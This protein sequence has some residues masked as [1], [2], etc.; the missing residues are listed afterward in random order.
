[1]ASL[2]DGMGRAECGMCLPPACAVISGRDP[3]NDNCP[4][5]NEIFLHGLTGGAAKPHADGWLL[6]VHVGQAGMGLMDS[7][8]LDEI[9]FPIRVLEERLLVDTEGAGR[10]CG[11][12]A[13]VTVM[14]ALGTD[15]DVM[16]GIDGHVFPAA[17]V[18][19][20][21]SGSPSGARVRLAT[22]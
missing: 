3:R 1:M 13:A 5:I 22:G 12:P 7:I 2:R 8:E 6:E 9:S 15:I 11:S 21:G 19:G 14:Q 10:Q 16:Y 17:G 4:F 20:G 18:R